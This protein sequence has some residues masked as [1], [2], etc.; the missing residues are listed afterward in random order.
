MKYI[1]KEVNLNT[2]IY[3]LPDNLSNLEMLI[4]MCR[5]RLMMLGAN[6]PRD[7]TDSENTKI[8]WNEHVQF[9]VNSIVDDLE[10]Y[11]HDKTLTKIAIGNP[12]LVEEIQ[13]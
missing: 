8:E 12:D 7:V 10:E 2:G 11:I 1:I 9:E 4:I 6:S 5:E 3:D 13:N